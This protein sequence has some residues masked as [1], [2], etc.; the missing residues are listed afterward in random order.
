M[1]EKI[2]AQERGAMQLNAIR[3]SASVA[4]QS[5][6]P[7][8]TPQN[9]TEV[10]TAAVSGR[11]A[12]EFCGL[13][14]NFPALSYYSNKA[15]KNSLRPL[16]KNDLKY[17]AGIMEIFIDQI[18]RRV[19]NP[20]DSKNVALKR[21]VPTVLTKLHTELSQ[22]YYPFTIERETL[23]LA[24]NA[25]NPIDY[26]IERVISRAYDLAEADDEKNTKALLSAAYNEGFIMPVHID[27]PTGEN[28]GD[29]AA[30]VNAT[31]TRMSKMRTDFNYCGVETSTPVDKMTLVMDADFDALYG[32][33]FIAAAF[34][35]DYA[36]IPIDIITIDDFT[37]ATGVKV[38]LIDKEFTQIY[39]KLRELVDNF[40]GD[41][42]YRTYYLHRWAIYSLSPF[43]NA[44]AFTTAALG[45][46][47]ALTVTPESETYKAGTSMYLNISFTGAGIYSHSVE[48]SISGATDDTTVCA[49]GA[50]YL[51][52]NETGSITVT[53]TSK[54]APSVTGSATITASK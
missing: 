18:T 13:L 31:A 48:W 16:W 44:V 2:T 54:A 52:K 3:N 11:F 9:L 6:V 50:I 10:Y 36:R 47:T 37:A 33:R 27:E 19:Y 22:I 8:A 25:E 34:N 51:G 4:Y 12:N 39:D 7:I 23:E 49:G 38:M 40:V 26:L 5:A 17:G 1:A 45:A 21:W 15:Y 14:Y 29:I 30:K 41:G 42:L 53:A 43:C 24:T 32:M 35:K 46:P 28:I 20:A